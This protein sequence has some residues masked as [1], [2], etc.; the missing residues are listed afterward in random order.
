MGEADAGHRCPPSLLEA[1]KASLARRDVSIEIG[2]PRHRDWQERPGNREM[3]D[4]K[5]NRHVARPRF[6]RPRPALV[7]GGRVPKA[8]ASR[9]AIVSAS[10]SARC[11]RRRTIRASSA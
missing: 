11:A 1:D 7:R 10:G 4:A 5:S 3:A 2:D 8:A 9:A 6:V